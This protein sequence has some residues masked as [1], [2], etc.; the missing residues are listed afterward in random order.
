MCGPF[1]VS[2]LP[3]NKVISFVDEYS[4]MMWLYLI[5]AKG[6]VIAVFKKFKPMVEKQS[7]KAM[8]ILETKGGGE[9]T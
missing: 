3:K 1:E 7:E 4:C 2:F 5:K 8:K 6:D 9:Y